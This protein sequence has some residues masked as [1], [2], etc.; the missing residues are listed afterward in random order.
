MTVTVPSL[1]GSLYITNP[2]SIIAYTLRKFS[3]TPSDTIPIL[4]S[5]IISL[6]WLV[7]NYKN[8]PDILCNNI[9]TALQNTLTNI[10]SPDNRTIQVLAT[11]TPSSS[12]NGDYDITISIVY[13]TLSGDLEQTGTTVSVVNGML[14]I[15]E[16]NINVNL[17]SSIPTVSS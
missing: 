4:P 10:F 9:Q 8:S 5:K 11:N 3:R 1:E 14:K 6:P 15:P 7:A 12:N 13:Q 2:L 16:D 17:I